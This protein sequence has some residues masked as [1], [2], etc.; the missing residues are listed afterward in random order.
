MK[1]MISS[2][3]PHTPT[4]Y[5]QQTKE[6]MFMLRNAG[7]EI[8]I[9]GW[10]GLTGGP[11]NIGDVIMLPRIGEPYGGDAG[12]WVEHWGAD[13]L[14]TLQDIWVL[15]EHFAKTL[16]CP[17][18][19]LFPI[20]GE[21]APPG[22]A[23]R[24]KRAAYP[25]AY[26]RFGLRMAREAGIEHAHYIP[27]MIDTDTFRPKGD[28]REVRERHNVDPDCFLV[29]MVAAN[30]GWPARKSFAECLEAFALFWREH[31]EARLY[32]HTERSAGK[33]MPF[34][35]LLSQLE[36]LY[37]FDPDAVMFAEQREYK[38][39]MSRDYLADVYTASDVLLS[40]SMGEGFGL[41]IAEAQACGC[42]VITQK[43]TSMTELTINGIA[44]EPGQ[45]MFTPLG[46]WQYI[47]HVGRIRD[48]L[49]WVYNRDPGDAQRA[50]VA[51]REYFVENYGR[52]AIAPLWHALI[53]RAAQDIGEI[54]QIGD[55]TAEEYAAQVS[56]APP[57]RYR[58]EAPNFAV[59]GGV[60]E[61]NGSGNAPSDDD[62]AAGGYT[63]DDAQDGDAAI[64]AVKKVAGHE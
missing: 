14:I 21:P 11:L 13:L 60:T 55:V 33:G 34:D 17:W 12:H 54:G 52:Q 4:G 35:L 41:P 51:G 8:A 45:G 6:I 46:H 38:L 42:P 1:I 56:M 18:V 58:H 53:E 7:H 39:G 10:W 9:F 47:P 50:A 2:N 29:S 30:K 62:G 5:G 22:V 49:E 31:P 26:S 24:A 64:A 16:K 48:A 36:S 20:D 25:V 19:A 37:G 63:G 28:K 61:A 44:I 43:V 57:I 27:H 3:A 23:K 15:P 59:S 40:P 32:L